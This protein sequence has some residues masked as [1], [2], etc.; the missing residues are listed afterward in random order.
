MQPCLFFIVSLFHFSFYFNFTTIAILSSFSGVSVL[1]FESIHSSRNMGH[2]IIGICLIVLGGLIRL[3]SMLYIFVLFAPILFFLDSNIRK[4]IVPWLVGLC[5]IMVSVSLLNKFSYSNH[6]DWQFFKVYNQERGAIHG[7]AKMEFGTDDEFLSRIGW[8]REAY[9]LFKDWIFIDDQVF[10][11]KSLETINNNYSSSLQSLDYVSKI[12]WSLIKFRFLEVILSI[13]IIGFSLYLIW[14]MGKRKRIIILAI[15]IYILLVN[16]LVTI[17]LRMVDNIFYPSLYVQNLALLLFIGIN[18]IEDKNK[19]RTNQLFLLFLVGIL[20]IKTLSLINI[21]HINIRNDAKAELI[22]ETTERIT[23]QS[24]NPLIILQ[25]SSFP[26]IW[27]SPYSAEGIPFDYVPTGWLIN[28]PPYK[29]ILNQHGINNLMAEIVTSND[30]YFLGADQ[31][32]LND[33][34]LYSKNI[35]TNIIEFEKFDLEYKDYKNITLLQFQK[36]Q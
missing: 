16:I 3:Q 1:V 25:G 18:P 30:I 7:T 36:P 2:Q 14:N 8:D 9:N 6:P 24:E 27:I 26:D 15:P 32:D 13:C 31:E 20:F 11:L 10:T 12:L 19:N 33:Y 29:N 21:D 17:V 35:K 4:R 5:V 23:N 34:L 28:S 22:I